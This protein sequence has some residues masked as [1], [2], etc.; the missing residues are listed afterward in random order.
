MCIAG[1]CKIGVLAIADVHLFRT[2]IGAVYTVFSYYV[3][4]EGREGSREGKKGWTEA[5]RGEHG[6]GEGGMREE[7]GSRREGKEGGR[8]A[9][10]GRVW[11]EGG[12]E[13][14]GRAA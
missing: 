8:Q 2:Y 9:C 1:Y 4:E 6:V 3:M 5:G 7:G 14:G 10:R 11:R 13:E 12:M